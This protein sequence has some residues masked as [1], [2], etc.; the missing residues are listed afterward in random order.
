[1][2]QFDIILATDANGGIGKNNS[3]PWHI[4]EDFQFFRQKTS[5]TEL[6]NQQNVIIMGRKTYE[7]IGIALSGRLNI[8][9][10]NSDK[11]YDNVIICKS[12]NDALNYVFTLNNIHN[13]F[14]IGG[15]MLYD[16]TIRHPLLR[17]IYLSKI[18]NNYDCDVFFNLDNL[19]NKHKFKLE[20]ETNYCAYDIKSSHMVNVS[21]FRYINLELGELQYLNLLEN[22][23]KYGEKRDTRNSITYSDFGGQIRFNL[24]NGFPLLT[25]KKT[26]MRGIFEEAKYLMLMGNTNTNILSE[27]GVKIWEP[28]TC[29]EFLDKMKLDYEIGDVGPMYGFQFRHF[30]A[31]YKG[32]NEDYEGKGIDQ[33]ANCIKLLR[34]DPHNRRIIMTTFNPQQANKGVLYPCH[35]IVVQFYV[36]TYNDK[37]MLCCHM[38]QR[39]C[40]IICG[41]P[42]NIASYALI[43]HILTNILGDNYI[44]GELIMSFGDLHIYDKPDHLNAVK[45]HLERIPFEFPKLN[46]KK[47]INSLDDLRNME[48]TDTEIINYQSHPSIKVSMVA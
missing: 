25:T 1:M 15:G 36:K 16:E 20:N 17:Y 32:M 5:Y 27:K 21:V 18:N 10:S 43:L 46:I 2:K 13:I 30:N 29:Q 35:G 9:I 24:Q 38:Y 33:L 23:L 31:E 11:Q 26:F 7:S 19:T 48:F 41:L 34:D 14:V 3:L 28:N 22:T 4:K 39:S 47:K 40:D 45:L 6:P 42:F 8:V 44:V 12:F 37:Y